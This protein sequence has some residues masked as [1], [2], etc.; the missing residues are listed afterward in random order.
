MSDT[1]PIHLVCLPFGGSGA[2]FFHPW[3]QWAGEG[4]TV[5]PLR[6]PGRERLIDEEPFRDVR[7]ATDRLL[8]DL[9]DELGG[10]ARVVLFGHSVGAVLAYEL[11]HRLASVPEVEVLRLF[12]SGSPEPGTQR[13]LR[14]TGLPD[15]A[16]LERVGEISGY[17][18]EALAVPDIRE[19]L[20]PTLRA[21]VEMHEE[22]RPSTL[23][24]LDVP[25][26]ALRGTDDRLVSTEQ[27]AAWAQVTRR[28]FT[29]VELPGAHMYL[30]DSGERVM[31]LIETATL[32]ETTA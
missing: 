18:H 31:R 29:L 13:T 3:A 5:L 26:T 25:I 20:L 9:L 1:T 23:E 24:P 28:E 8:A 32:S 7:P 30:V 15:D 21:D 14:A 2:S 22:Y 16:F 12:A 17:R 4:R 19:L 11:A 27:L 10:P 6:L